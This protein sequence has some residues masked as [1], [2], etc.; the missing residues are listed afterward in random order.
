MTGVR[1]GDFRKGADVRRGGNVLQSVGAGAS[2]TYGPAPGD[3]K[4]L[5]VRT[6]SFHQA[7][8]R[9]IHRDRADIATCLNAN[10]FTPG[11]A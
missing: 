5:G 8:R 11:N 9:L 4:K 2:A 1:D 10:V 3:G 6:A 7:A